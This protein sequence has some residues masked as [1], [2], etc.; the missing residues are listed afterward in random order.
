MLGETRSLLADGDL[1][2]WGT[3]EVNDDTSSKLR[4]TWNSPVPGSRGWV[5]Y[6]PI[7]SWLWS[8]ATLPNGGL[9]TMVS[10]SRMTFEGESFRLTGGACAAGF[11]PESVIMTSHSMRQVSLKLHA[12][13]AWESNNTWL[14]F[15]SPATG[16]TWTAG[17]SPSNGSE[18]NSTETDCTSLQSLES[19]ETSATMDA[20]SD[21]FGPDVGTSD[22]STDAVSFFVN[23]SCGPGKTEIGERRF[24]L[25]RGTSSEVSKGLETVWGFSLAWQVTVGCNWATDVEAQSSYLNFEATLS[26][27][28]PFARHV[29]SWSVASLFTDSFG[30]TFAKDDPT[31]EKMG[32]LFARE[33]GTTTCFTCFPDLTI[34][35]LWL[36]SG[37]IPVCAGC[38]L[39]LCKS[40]EG[41][42]AQ[43]F[44]FDFS[45][46]IL[47]PL[48]VLAGTLAPAPLW[49]VTVDREMP[50][51]GLISATLEIF[52]L[53]SS[54][55]DGFHSIPSCATSACRSCLASLTISLAAF[56]NVRPLRPATQI[57]RASL[58]S[59]T[60]V[61]VS[62][63]R[64]SPLT[65]GAAL[66]S[67]FSIAEGGAAATEAM[68]W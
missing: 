17:S 21:S 66:C 16:F 64:L 27:I 5:S 29:T 60:S 31:L 30:G 63:P 3:G 25:E 68:V 40:V 44:A 14:S 39:F 26:V 7:S 34:S 19:E 54:V 41:S 55:S 50:L 11:C 59:R 45:T 13:S 61:S 37:V 22:I 47:Q 24:F 9:T 36:P 49:K 57:T 43:D 65:N 4:S 56:P 2:A 32:T 23:F 38:N 53:F 28:L 10:L 62:W 15:R 58:R 12:A 51:F 33:L 35:W 48:S 6:S 8:A 46:F 18:Y 42:L 1:D 67:M 52:D 20:F